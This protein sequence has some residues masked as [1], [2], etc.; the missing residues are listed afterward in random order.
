MN[1]LFNKKPIQ[2]NKLKIII[3]ICNSFNYY[4]KI[5]PNFIFLIKKKTQEK[6]CSHEFL[7]QC[8]QLCSFWLYS[9]NID[10]KFLTCITFFM[11]VDLHIRTPQISIGPFN[12]SRKFFLFC[13]FLW[14]KCKTY[15]LSYTKIHFNLLILCLF[16]S[17]F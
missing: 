5:I 11:Q 12:P 15:H 8:Q 3:Q 14:L 1:K 4:I 7:W 9:H 16:I 6:Y 13:D 2:K 17:I 10:L